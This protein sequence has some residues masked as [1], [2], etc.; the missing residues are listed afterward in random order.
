MITLYS[1]NIREHAAVCY[2]TENCHT[3]NISSVG[4]GCYHSETVVIS[5]GGGATQAFHIVYHPI[6]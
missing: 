4:V 5:L 6:A 1:D 2:L 3:R